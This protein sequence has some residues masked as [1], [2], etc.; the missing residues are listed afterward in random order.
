MVA[1]EAMAYDSATV[2]P[3]MP[4]AERG[5]TRKSNE[6]WAASNTLNVTVSKHDHR[7]Q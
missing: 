5:I 3:K 2:V 7:I 6:V 1:K 4:Y